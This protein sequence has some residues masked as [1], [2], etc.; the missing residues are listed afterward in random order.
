MKKTN[1]M[2][3]NFLRVG[4]CSDSATDS[5]DFVFE[6]GVERGG[7]CDLFS[8][9]GGEHF[10]CTECI[11]RYVASKLDDILAIISYQVSDCR[12]VLEPEYC[13]VILTKGGEVEK[14]YCPFC[15]KAFCV[16]CMVPWHS[17]ICRKFQKLKKKG[18][19]VMLKDLAKRKT[20]RRCQLC[21]NCVEESTGFFYIYEV[22]FFL[23]IVF[24]WVIGLP[25]SVIIL[26]A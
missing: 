8:L 17:H 11:I 10:Y 15:K 3:G 24:L 5:P 6:I 14:S 7:L 9:K 12:G 26:L 18:E 4:E 21:K 20:W 2:T 22:G 25:I 16:E 13:R 1:M 19:D 23:G